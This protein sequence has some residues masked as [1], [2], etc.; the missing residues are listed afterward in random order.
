MYSNIPIPETPKPTHP[1]TGQVSSSDCVTMRTRVSSL[2]W[3]IKN[4]NKAKSTKMTQWRLLC[5]PFKFWTNLEIGS[6]LYL[7]IVKQNI[8]FSTL[9]VTGYKLVN[10][11]SQ[12]LNA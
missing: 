9:E 3:V 8:F 6:L 12:C 7:N 2:H 11:Q 5:G 10:P 1:N 4:K